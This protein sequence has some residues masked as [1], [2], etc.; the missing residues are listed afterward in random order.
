M[1]KAMG[2]P[3]WPA[4][5]ALLVPNRERALALARVLQHV[6]PLDALV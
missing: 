6:A 3:V 4:T 1:T 5:A 2:G